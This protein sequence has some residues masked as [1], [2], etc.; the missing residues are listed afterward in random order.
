MTKLILVQGSAA[1]FP[2]QAVNRG[3]KTFPAFAAGDALTAQVFAG[4]NQTA[5][6]TPTVGWYT[7]GG[8]QT[9]YGQ[10]QV[11]V[12]ITAAQA[13]TL[14]LNG[15]FTLEV[16]W[17]PAGGGKSACIWR[18][19]LAVETAAGT[20]TQPT[21]T[22]CTLADMLR[23]APW[24]RLVQD[25]DT[26]QE[27]FWSQRVEARQWLDNLI[28]RSWRG[29]SAAYFGDSGRSAQFWL[30]SWVRRTPL[31]S[32]WL[33]DQLAGGFFLQGGISI[34]NAGSGY[35]QPPTVTVQAPGGTGT[36]ASFTATVS[37][38][39]IT[40]IYPNTQGS[41]YVPGQVYTLTIS[42]GGGANGAATATAS[43]GVLMLRPHIV[44]VCA[45]KA[46]SLV[47]EGQIGL[48]NQQ[49]EYGSYFRD[50]AASEALSLVA[51]LDLNGDGVAD[52]PIPLSP[53][54]SMFT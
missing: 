3:G 31:P 12:S 1:D 17:Q 7:A 11:L 29:T 50:V 15:T 2:L 52:L 20:A 51:E 18:G 41:G 44:R 27:G 53:S 28:V 16:W 40:S 36:T 37:L 33:Q 39:Q 48:N 4:Q 30:G 5:L 49:A 54:N 6:F 42:G 43:L 14:E 8:T 32:K 26:D 25:F 22:Y 35:S 13:A 23:F 24:V 9:G 19:A 46:I 47:G 38:G 21:P 10:G 45:M 34:T